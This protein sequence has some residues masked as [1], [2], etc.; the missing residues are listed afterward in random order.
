M[1]TDQNKDM[2]HRFLAELDKERCAIVNFLTPIAWH[3]SPETLNPH[4][5]T[6]FDNLS[7]CSVLRSQTCII[8]W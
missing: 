4:A 3:I 2:V 1:I 5:A 7:R 6:V 8:M